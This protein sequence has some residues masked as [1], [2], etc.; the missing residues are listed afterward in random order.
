MADDN[1]QEGQR[2]ATDEPARS[3]AECAETLPDR[4]TE[5]G[6]V[7]GVPGPAFVVAGLGA[8][9]GGVEALEAFFAGLP[10]VDG[11]AFVVILHLAPDE[12]SHLADVLQGGLPLPVTQVTESVA[13]RPG[14]VYVIPP[15][16]NLLIED[17]HLVLEPIEEERV[18]RR[19]IDHFFRTL[20]DAY[21]EH[22][23]GVILSGTG[24]NGT[25]GAR[26]LR[27]VGGC[28][29]AQDPEDARFEEMPR[30]ALAAGIVDVVGTAGRLAAEAAAYAERL[31][32][33]RL[34]ETP[35]ALPEDGQKALQH[36][37]AQ[38][39]ARTG[40][41]FAHYKRSTVLRRLDRRLHVTGADSLDAYLDRLRADAGEAAV[42]L[43]DLLIS[44]T[45]FFRDA[46][47][48]AALESAVPRL[49]EGKGPE[50]E[51]RVWVPGC[52]TGE[53][54]YSIAMLLL[55][56]AA[57]LAEPPAVQVFA[58]DLSEAAVR[59][60]REGAYPESIEADVSAERLRRFFTHDSGHYRVSEPLREAVLFAPHSLLKDPPF[61]RLDLVSC[62]NLLIYL[63]RDLQQKVLAL[64]HYA[65]RP[66]GLLFLGT[67]ESADG[68]PDLFDALDKGARLY[69]RL[70]VETPAPF[71]PHV[72]RV[73]TEPPVLPAAA[74]LPAPPEPPP[75]EFAR[76][77]QALREETAPPSV[78]VNEGGEVVHVSDDAAPF[79]QVS[80]GAPTRSLVKLLRPELRAPVQ[81]ALFQA[82]RDGAP[83]TSG[84]VT[85][86][87]GS[88]DRR[89]G[90]RAR[91]AGSHG[92]GLVQVVFEM[93]AEAARPVAAAA[94]DA[95]LVA[96]LEE[97]LGGAREQVRVT[98]EE[99]ETSREE[100][101]SQNEELQ[102]VNEEL[103][104]TAEELETSKE[105]AQS[106]AE[107]LR[108]VNDELKAKVDE[109]ARAKGDLE[110]LI[111][112]TEIATLF[113][114]RDLCI[115][116]FTPHVR[117][118]FHVLASDL[119]RP[120]EDLAQ[121]FGGVRLVEDAE[122]VV[123][124]LEVK[125]REVEGTDGR[126]YLVHARP[127]RTAEDRIAG[128]VVTFV[129]ITRRKADEAALAA[130]AARTAFRVALADAFREHTA[131]LAVQA[132]ATRLLGQHLGASRVHYGEI[133]GGVVVVA[134]D[135]TDGVPSLSGA[136]E[137]DGFGPALI[138]ALRQGR[139]LV[140]PD[141]DASGDLSGEA[142]AAYAEI[143]IAAQIGVPLVRDGRLRAVL[144]VHQSAPRAWTDAEVSLA[145]ETAERTWAAVER[146]RAEDA[147]RAN[148]AL[149][150]ATLSTISD[151]AYAFDRAGRILFVNQPLLDLWGLELADAVGKTF[152]ELD[153]PAELADRLQLQI[154]QV[155]ETAEG[156]TDETPYTG[157]DGEE[158]FYE[159]IFRPLLADDGSVSLVVGSTRD[160]TSR[161]RARVALQAEADRAGF[162]ADLADTLRALSDPVEA[163]AEAARTLG[164][165]LGASRVHY[166]ELEPDGRHA[167]VA[168]DYARTAPD[169]SGRYAL[170]DFSFL[171]AEAR[172]GRTLVVPHVA[173]D[174]RLSPAEREEYAGLPVAA[175]VVVP[176]VKDG[177]LVALFAVHHGAPHD[178]TDAEVALV[179]ETA[180]RTWAAVER[181][182]AE[183]A[184]RQSE[185]RLRRVVEAVPDLLFTATPEGL[186]DYAS[187][188]MS[189]DMDAFP[190]DLEG[191]LAFVHPD[192]REH[193]GAAWREAVEHGT[194]YES[195]HRIRQPDGSYRWFIVRARLAP[196]ADGAEAAW[197]G[198]ATDIDALVRAEA[199]VRE[200]NRT[201]EERVEERTSEVR[202]L[203]ARLTVAEQEERQRIAQVLHDDLQQQLFGLGLTLGLARSA[204]PGEEAEELFDQL[205]EIHDQATDL[206]RSLVVELSPPVLESER[207]EE[208]L[209]WLAFQKEEQHGLTVEVEVEEPCE[210]PSRPARVL[211]YQVLGELLFNVVK[212]AGTRHARLRAWKE[213]GRAVVEVGDDGYGFDANAL[214]EQPQASGG[215]G[216]PS[217]RERVELVGGDV[218][219]ASAPGDGTR[220]VVRVP[221]APGPE[222]QKA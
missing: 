208:I 15:N 93:R 116:R 192:D 180:E 54:A 98:N 193:A 121:K 149:F 30:T 159:Y 133:E 9:A 129:D 38:L 128:V 139:T 214:K 118:H 95:D 199:E 196:A 48:F 206:T 163:Q 13:V 164:E 84:P 5:D 6:D 43:D 201:L 167:V 195:R 46:R 100:L 87:V 82:R 67:S 202:A 178:W 85:L 125:E 16:K 28:V 122:A 24:A 69:R 183:D 61:S 221:A 66:G 75:G 218:E 132:Q 37:L 146:A 127:Y 198:T 44:V 79:L 134:Q 194:P 21:G 56:H 216:L 156:L 113:L 111:V 18:E 140:M 3:D 151:F 120:L 175:L 188:Q 70:D 210:V 204:H 162:R 141:L 144:S 35:E 60:A 154:E 36:V 10:E 161:Y 88:E 174:E 78:L 172:A 147:L 26:R 190:M 19:P 136:F 63:Q 50:D 150:D 53:E 155:F 76:L 99:F 32:E 83:A 107:E 68:G 49:F 165:H 143:G 112:S 42:L 176:L 77:H 86:T 8:S 166:A 90:V 110:N 158:G 39:R 2:A 186:I 20:A 71:L 148:E 124:R 212:H 189:A 108:T 191:W 126:W 103:R 51:L 62:R 117:D 101:R 14:H 104:S 197:Y 152:H 4:G 41:D 137:M 220:V 177:G 185:E 55:E 12:E 64:F 131:P 135:Y 105:E 119:G 102:S 145:E 184:L 74:P 169:R 31:R 217:V 52:A 203:S 219:I 1:H 109:T 80:G 59:T 45:N 181:A 89:V 209:L 153:Y 222:T 142:R 25:V 106:M 182:R 17:G 34:P 65:L 200:L 97:E 130:S 207:L 22:A 213:D 11:I 168:R 170:S 23:V 27:E 171:I 179:E 94:H 114:D 47:A 57:T 123:D 205:G 211:L 173:D 91:P 115:K 92:G 138:E 40:H 157:A 81:T 33:E 215:F 96:V 160:V 73:L 7:G 187:S 29:M 58:S 72:P